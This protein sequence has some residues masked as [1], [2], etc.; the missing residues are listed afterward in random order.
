MKR[1]SCL[2]FVVLS[3]FGSHAFS[4]LTD[5]NIRNSTDL[6]FGALDTKHVD[7]FRQLLNQETLIRMTLVKNVHALMKDMVTLQQSLLSSE[8]EISSLK[9]TTTREITELK[10]E[11]RSLKLENNRLSSKVTRCNENIESLKENITEVDAS[12]RV[13]ETQLIMEKQMFERNTSGIL[14]D[15]KTEVRYLSTT[16]LD[17]NKHTL[18]LDKNI[19]ELIDNRYVLIS[20]SLN[21]SLDAYRAEMRSTNNKLNV[22][23]TDLQKTQQTM[24]DSLSDNMNNTMEGLKSEVKQTQFE[25]LKLSSAV[26]SLEVFR[27]NFTN[28][29]CGVSTNVAFTAG[30]TS[31]ASSWTGSILVFPKII[32]NTGGGYDP[33]T[34]MFTTP[35]D[36][37][38][39]FFVSVQSY[40][41]NEIR[42][43][44]VLNGE[45][46]VRTMA[47]DGSDKDYY[48]AGVNLVVLRLN[49]GDK[50]WVKR[51]TGTGYYSLSVPV[52]TF[53]GFLL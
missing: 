31:S 9:D 46:K 2:S 18:E 7:V 36:G 3:L 39:V 29:Q 37:H 5:G 14:A 44:I 21:D 33:T 10:K 20:G 52:T 1:L 50:V 16:L 41:T 11:V 12:R 32:F 43:D 35:V 53:S 4:I 34:G 47:Y 23:L 13:F 30:I 19:P 45:S 42:M 49:Q 15:I 51:Y 28:R 17:L 8:S 27:L 6:D 25:Q 26:S 40:G 24:T 48:E 22:A 38:Y